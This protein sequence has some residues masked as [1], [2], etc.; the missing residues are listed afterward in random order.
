MSDSC[1]AVVAEQP[2][3]F[4]GVVAVVDGELIL[5]VVGLV[6]TRGLSTDCAHPALLQGEAVV[7]VESDAVPVLEVGFAS[8]GGVNAWWAVLVCPLLFVVV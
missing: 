2:S 5:P 4:A 3:D 8:C 6:G 1:V 7:F